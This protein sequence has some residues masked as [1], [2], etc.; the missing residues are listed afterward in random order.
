M[1]KFELTI[2]DQEILELISNYKEDKRDIAVLK[3]LKVGLVALKDVETVGNV[4]YV[5]KEF[6][7]FKTDLDKE[8]LLL[9]EEFAS[10]LKETDE[11]V[12]DKLKGSFDPDSGIMPRVLDKYL[13]DGGKLSDLFDENNNTSAVSK[14]KTILSEYFDTDASRVYKLLDPN[15]PDSPLSSFKNDM[16]ERLIAIEKEI[17]AK[18]SAEEA[19]KAESE[20]GT[21]KGFAYED[22]VFAQIEKIANIFGDTCLPTGKETGQVLNSKQGDDVVTLNPSQTGG[23]TLK[24]VFEAKDKEMYLSSLLDELE[25]AKK[26]RGADIAVAVVSGKDT[27][28]DVKEVIGMFRDYSNRRMI[29]ILDKE[30]PDPIALE[31]AY[32]LARAKLL[33][34]LQAKAMKSEFIDVAAINVLIDEI[35]KKLS[36]F[37]A[38]KSTL[39]KASSA[40]GNAQ[41]EIDDMKADLISK[42]E[43]LSEKA[44][45]IVK[46]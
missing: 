40:I 43:D 8:F 16:S 6:Q 41:T 13:G 15:N 21:Q 34:S 45:P 17:R 33:L 23:A 7:K 29:C 22:I 39:T 1:D 2:T 14:I 42:L 32:K 30:N 4:D 44:K 35:V 5:E 38:I 18:S 31:V 37:S 11:L 10:K 24:I 12:A 46:K 3:A 36:E 19:A 26:N 27:L 9:K 28:K 25:G 20:K